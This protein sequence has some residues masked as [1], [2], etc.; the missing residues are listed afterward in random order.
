[1]PIRSTTSPGTARYIVRRP[2]L[3]L[4]IVWALG[5]SV[6]GS[7]VITLGLWAMGLVR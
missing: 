7:G 6:A 5:T 3:A 1:M 4:D 2:R